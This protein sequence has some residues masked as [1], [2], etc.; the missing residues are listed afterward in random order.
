MRDSVAK[1][2]LRRSP[3]LQETA[4]P[5]SSINMQNVATNITSATGSSAISAEQSSSN[6]KSSAAK[7]T[8]QANAST[9]AKA[10]AASSKES[11]PA[12]LS[13]TVRAASV[14]GAPL[15]IAT[16]SNSSASAAAESSVLANSSHNVIT[17]QQ[18][19]HLFN[20]MK[21]LEEQLRNTQVQLED[22]N[23]KRKALEDR[24]LINSFSAVPSTSSVAV[25]S[26][27]GY[28]SSNMQNGAIELHNGAN[29]NFQST[30]SNASA[31]S[32]PLL[33]SPPSVSR[34]RQQFFR[35]AVN[36]LT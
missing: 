4:T 20:K 19:S 5:E 18:V 34:A 32:A 26:A 3:R 12:N 13:A 8:G 9:S 11:T 33:L 36:L 7:G 21:E 25:S 14:Q 28:T 27:S 35:W 16:T 29:R 31:A 10:A 24:C 1:G 23:K 30:S 15:K 17:A 2:M 6:E 22:S